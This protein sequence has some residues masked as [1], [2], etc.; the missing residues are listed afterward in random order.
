MAAPT[1]IDLDSAGNLYVPNYGNFSGS[2][3]GVDRV[4]IIGAHANGCVRNAMT[5]AGPNTQLNFPAGLRI[6]ASGAIYVS[7]GDLGGSNS[8]AVY[9]AGSRG[10]RHQSASS[11]ARLPDSTTPIRSRSIPRRTS[12]LGILRTVRTAR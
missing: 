8:I 4:S 3:S 10:T 1:A 7:N 12:T 2:T 5:I 11:K 6:G 9:A